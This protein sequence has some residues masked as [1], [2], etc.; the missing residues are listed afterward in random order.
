[1]VQELKKPPK[2]FWGYQYSGP[3]RPAFVTKQLRMPEPIE[4]PDRRQRRWEVAVFVGRRRL[5][6]VGFKGTTPPKKKKKKSML[7]GAPRKTRPYERCFSLVLQGIDFTAG[8]ILIF[9]PKTQHGGQ[10]NS[11]C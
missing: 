1:M 3:L 5:V 6:F 9:P 10:S 4:L 8:H 7:E 11:E 2:E